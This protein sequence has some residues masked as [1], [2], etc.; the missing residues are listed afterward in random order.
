MTTDQALATIVPFGKHLGR[1]LAVVERNEPDYIDAILA[2][3]DR[4]TGEFREACEALVELRV[5]RTRRA[6]V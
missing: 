3:S 1:P 2:H 5:E 4:C 6:L